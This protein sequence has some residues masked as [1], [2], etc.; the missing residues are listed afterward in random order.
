M[1]KIGLALGAGGARGLAHIVILEA[2][3]ELK[4]KPS[5]IAGS[6]IGAILGAF[7]SAGFSSQEM[8]S[9]V[10]EIIF[11][12]KSK[13]WE[14]HKKSDFIKYFDLLDPTIKT[15]GLLKGDKLIKFLN[16][17]LKA[18]YFNELEIP[19][20]V[21]V[22]DYNNK[23]QLVI[24]DGE[25]LSAVRSSYA[26]PFLFSPVIRDKKLLVDGGMVNPLPFDVLPD[27]CDIIIAVDVSATNGTPSKLEIPPS[28]EIL[29]SA[30]QIMQSSIIN[31]KLKV[32]KPDIHIKTNIKGVRVHEFMKAEQ[33]FK[34]AEPYKEEL[35]TKL[36]GLLKEANSS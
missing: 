10:S 15:G 31:A 11:G 18:K 33:I 16:Q 30:F 3:E 13:F 12:K 24:N 22:T 35:K 7:Y 5:F 8:R 4:I 14:I 36:N 20:Q 6:S 17:R 27:E 25:L 32:S 9:I 29:F 1:K 2:L 26:L 21:V 19:F 28:Y 34:S 23:S